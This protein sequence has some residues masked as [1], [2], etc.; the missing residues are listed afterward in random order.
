[1]TNASDE[2]LLAGLAAGDRDAARVIVH[3]FKA[4]VFGLAL[5][6][7]HDRPSAEDVSQEVFLRVWRHASSFDPRRGSAAAWILTVARNTALDHLTMR[8]RRL[9]RLPL[10]PLDAVLDTATAAPGDE[11][12][13]IADAVN[14]L[15][16]EQ[17]D[18]LI[19]AAYHGFTAREISDAWNVPLGTVKTR[20]RSALHKLRDQLVEATP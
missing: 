5:S 16:P 10:E 17:R 1:V 6:I 19:A 8:D 12:L 7:I 3:R 14:A 9:D 11:T 2:A 15:P 13:P 4:R 18:T 20:L